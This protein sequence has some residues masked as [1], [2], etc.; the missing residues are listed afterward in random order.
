MDM[1][2]FRGKYIMR[3]K[4]F[5]TENTPDKPKTGGVSAYTWFVWRSF[6]KKFD[7]VSF[8]RYID[9]K[10]YFREGFYDNDKLWWTD[11]SGY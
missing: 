5:M 2:Y 4:F 3:P 6:P 1:C 11:R 8:E 10:Q 9:L 7:A